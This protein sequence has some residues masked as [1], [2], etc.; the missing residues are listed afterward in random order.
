MP[1]ALADLLVKARLISHIDSDTQ[2]L[3]K[4]TPRGLLLS[5]ARLRD[6]C[7]IFEIW[8]IIFGFFRATQAVICLPIISKRTEQS[9]HPK[10]VRLAILHSRFSD[11]GHG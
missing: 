10:L 5:P 6:A 7:T 11:K 4:K 9:L 8:Q 2:A 3:Q 1:L